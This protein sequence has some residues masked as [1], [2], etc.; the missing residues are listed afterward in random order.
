MVSLLPVAQQRALG[1]MSP[2]LG[3]LA[4]GPTAQWPLLALMPPPLLATDQS[5]TCSH[6][7]L[8]M[9]G[10][11]RRAATPSSTTTPP[12]ATPWAL[13]TARWRLWEKCPTPPMSPRRRLRS[14]NLPRLQIPPRCGPLPPSHRRPPPPSRR[15]PH[16]HPRHPLPIRWRSPHRLL[17]PKCTRITRLQATN[18]SLPHT[19]HHWPPLLMHWHAPRP[20]LR[21]CQRPQA[22]S[23][24]CRRSGSSW[25]RHPSGCAGTCWTC[26]PQWSMSKLQWRRRWRACCCGSVASGGQAA[27]G[28]AHA[29]GSAGSRLC[30]SITATLCGP[31]GHRPSSPLGSF[32]LCWALPACFHVAWCSLHAYSSARCKHSDCVTRIV[33]CRV[34]A[35]VNESASQGQSTV[36]SGWARKTIN[37]K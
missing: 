35:A 1:C 20:L 17:R 34:R 26:I 14:S 24:R 27:P 8:Q 3:C 19:L 4:A 23:R 25:R 15:H 10:R 28:P 13:A 18:R 2:Q 31:L 5:P 36:G 30:P 7:F 12:P 11:R 33:S 32:F 21:R 16:L 37:G 9:R 6:P 22:P 29:A